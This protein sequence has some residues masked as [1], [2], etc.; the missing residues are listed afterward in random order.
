MVYVVP[1]LMYP[2]IQTSEELSALML[3]RMAPEGNVKFVYS[4]QVLP[5]SVVC[6]MSGVPSPWLPTAHASVSL[7]A[8]T[9]F[10]VPL[11]VAPTVA[12]Q[13]DPLYLSMRYPDFHP[14]THH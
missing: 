7:I 8:A 13:D 2:A 4:D 9:L 11:P 1:V 12:V 5:L 3:C 14:L 6:R 10:R